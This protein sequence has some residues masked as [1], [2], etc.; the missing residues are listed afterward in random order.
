MSTEHAF[1]GEEFLTWLWFRLETDG[2]DFEL[3][4]ARTA[5]VSLDDFLA[6][7]PSEDDETEQTLRK[8]LPS[9]SAEARAGLRNGRRVR[10]MKLIVAIG[11]REWSLTVEGPTLNLQGVKLPP[12]PEDVGSREELAAER[13]AAFFEIRDVVATLYRRFLDERLRDDYKATA[14]EEQAQWMA[15]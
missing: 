7:A 3:A 12:D 15:G 6:F 9:R 10:R 11:D 13:A 2:G 14:G 1:L 4:D 5:S 8:G